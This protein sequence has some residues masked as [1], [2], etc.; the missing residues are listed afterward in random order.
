MDLGYSCRGFC[1]LCTS[2]D[3]SIYVSNLCAQNCCIVLLFC[4]LFL[5]FPDISASKESACNAGDLGSIPGLGRSSEEGKGYPLQ[6]SSLENSMDCIA[7]R[8]AKSW[9]G[10]SYFH[11]Q[12]TQVLQSCLLIS[13]SNFTDFCLLFSMGKGI[14]SLLIISKY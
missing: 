10:L 2:R 5:G 3:L 9:T 8:V 1:T 4:S 12:C 14:S 11:L 13:D 6:D 7:H